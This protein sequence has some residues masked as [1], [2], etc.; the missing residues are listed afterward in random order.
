MWT[1]VISS[2]VQ[3][4]PWLLT[5]DSVFVPQDAITPTPTPSTTPAPTLPASSPG[6]TS[7]SN[8]HAG[9]IAGGVVG[10]IVALAAIVGVLVV[11]LRKRPHT[12]AAPSARQGREM[13]HGTVMGKDHDYSE[14][15]VRFQRPQSGLRYPEDNPPNTSHS[16][17]VYGNY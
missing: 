3:F 15:D 2:T 6:A 12:A 13:E 17:N 5:A 14:G 9:P 11:C 4:H 16:G 1:L 10:G 8:S 7:P